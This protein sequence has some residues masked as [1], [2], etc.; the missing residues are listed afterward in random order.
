MEA[1][2]KIMVVEDELSIRSF[3]SINLQ[4]NGYEVSEA[5]NGEQ[6]MK[7]AERVRPDVVVLDIMMK[8]I[9]GFQVCKWL[10]TKFPEIGILL[11][12]AKNEDMDKVI[13]LE[14][15]ADDYMVKP[16]NPLELLARVKS[17]LRRQELMRE[18]QRSL[19]QQ[20]RLGPFELDFTLMRC[21]KKG[22]LIEL[23]PKEFQLLRILMEH[24][25]QPFTREQL[26][27][28]AWGSDFFGDQKIVDVNIRRLREKIEDSPSAP[29][30]ILT[31][32]GHGYRWSGGTASQR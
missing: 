10:R 8:G 30:H 13:G 24:P 21:R 4:D 2:Y 9:D 12:S 11:L 18:K 15:G 6:A 19:K 27:D 5:E 23:T 17:I 14:L 22:E 25:E 29:F 26:L 1:T 28:L 31:V 3:V 20:L 16:F 7:E 32:R